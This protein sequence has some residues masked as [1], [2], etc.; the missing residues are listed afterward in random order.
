[1]KLVPL[2]GDNRIIYVNPELVSGVQ[3]H[4]GS[5]ANIVPDMTEVYVGPNVVVIWETPEAVVCQLADNYLHKRF[6]NPEWKWQ[7]DGEETT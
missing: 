1:M 5:D 6:E 3:P 2:N 4:V 7:V